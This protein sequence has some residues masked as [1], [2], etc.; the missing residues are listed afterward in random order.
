MRIRA[1]RDDLADVLSRAARAIGARSPLPILQGVLV[2]VRGQTMRVTGTDLEVTVRT[3]LEVEVMEDG[4]TVI[5]ARLASE[6]VRKLP[7]GA[8][9][10]QAADGEVHISGGGPEFKFREL[11]ADDFPKVAEPDLEGAVEVDGA[12]FMD[13]L[14]QV[15]SAAST[16]D[17]RPILT[18]SLIHI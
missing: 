1:E 13:A 12:A 17:A 3:E 7:P 4:E 11:P 2:E 9:V 6:A 15:S 5:P 18:L 10:L 16:D 8:V 14:V